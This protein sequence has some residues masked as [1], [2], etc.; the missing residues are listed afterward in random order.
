LEN[1]DYDEKDSFD[2]KKSQ[3]D[4]SYSQERSF[5]DKNFKEVSIPQATLKITVMK[6]HQVIM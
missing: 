1:Q 5:Q 2:Q 6:N 4:E 3:R